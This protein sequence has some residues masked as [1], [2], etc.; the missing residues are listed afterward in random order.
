MYLSGVN[1]VD[2]HRM[3]L[4]V[5][6]SVSFRVWRW[7]EIPDGKERRGKQMAMQRGGSSSTVLSCTGDGLGLEPQR[8]EGDIGGSLVLVI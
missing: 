5:G 6:P 2:K 8:K 7:G 3:W 1:S 4:L